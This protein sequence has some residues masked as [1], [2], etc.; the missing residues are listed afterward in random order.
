VDGKGEGDMNK[1]KGR[2]KGGREKEWRGRTCPTK[3]IIVPVSLAHHLHYIII[4]RYRKYMA[5]EHLTS[6]SR[7]HI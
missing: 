1:E 2:G 5:D 4:N 6:E 7:S 3:K